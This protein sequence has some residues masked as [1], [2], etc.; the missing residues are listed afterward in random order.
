MADLIS[1]ITRITTGVSDQAALIEQI[2]A[3]LEGKAAGG[4]GGGG[5][6]FVSEF[7]P[8]QNITSSDAS[9]YVTINHN[10]GFVPK[11]ICV[12]RKDNLGFT[13]YGAYIIASVVY[14]SPSAEGKFDRI[15][16]NAYSQSTFS[17]TS[18][19]T[20]R[21]DKIYTYLL[22]QRDTIELAHTQGG[23]AALVSEVTDSHLTICGRQGYN[24]SF[25]H[26]GKE[27]I[28]LAGGS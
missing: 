21:T 2:K 26:A 28:V 17:N 22:K 23:T 7:V 11:V 3:A 19:F 8:A 5:G 9:T 27:Y 20:D 16:F 6:F 24:A 18:I 14:A 12:L 10:L 13:Q 25:I 15:L 1:K 4:G